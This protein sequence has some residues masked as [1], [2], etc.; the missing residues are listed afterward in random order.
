M[1][2]SMAWILIIVALI[3]G[4]CIGFLVERYRAT[5][6]LEATKMMMQDQYT[7][8]MNQ[9]KMQDQKMAQEQTAMKGMS[10]ITMMA[11]GTGVLVDDKGMT[12]YTYDK[13]TANKSNC[14]GACATAWPPYVVIGTAPTT[15]PAHL[16]TT[17]RTDG[18]V[19]YTYDTKP[20]YYYV[21]DTKAGDMTGD[22]VGGVWHVIK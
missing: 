15:L 3:L 5:G 11:K 18:S 16:G 22:G 4:G 14:Y 21:K 20:L 17:K 7:A 13:D 9:Q 8:Q 10:E 19:Q 2:K 6:K 12:L 1:K